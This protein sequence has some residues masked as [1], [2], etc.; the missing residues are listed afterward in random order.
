MAEK[1]LSKNQVIA[2][3]AR[4]SHGDLKQYLPI[5][6]SSAKEDPEF[7]AHL[8]AW[9][10]KNGQIRDSKIAL[11]VTSLTMWHDDELAENSLAHMALLDPRS[12]VKAVEFS[13]KIKTLLNGK[14]IERLVEAYLR[15]REKKRGW[16]DATALQHRASMKTLYAMNHIKPS[17]RADKIL[18]KRSY[19]KNSAF[20]ALRELKNMTPKD[21]AAAIINKELP[22]QIAIGALGAKAKDPDVVLALIEAMSPTQLT[23]S[24]KMLERLGLNTNPALKAAFEI[25]LHKVAASPKN[26]LKAT[27]AIEAL[28][29]EDSPIKEK[30]KKTQEKQIDAMG[31]VKG[32]WLVLGDKSGSMHEA[33]DTARHIAATLARM[34]EDDVWL[35]FFDTTPYKVIQA[36]GKTYDELLAESKRVTAGGG[37]SIG[38]GLQHIL[39]K[40]IEVDGIAVVSDGGENTH[41]V[42]PAVYKRYT[43]KFAKDVPVYYYDLNGEPNV[44]FVQ[45]MQKAGHDM[46]TF[47][48]R[49]SK[50]DYYSLPNLV[51][52]MSVSRYG[53]IDQIMET[54]LL[55]VKDVLPSSQWE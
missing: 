9:N 40:D 43:E 53:L 13:K 17:D 18:F 2:E 45:A 46:Q 6:K 24:V 42:F 23:N 14:A 50:V 12:L 30:L 25:G 37:T 10:E 29:E 16:W 33:I 20:Y 31:K 5:V 41:P 26:T 34:A 51:K 4:S 36:K 15:E 19:A 35:V 1:S 48:L 52:T 38:C 22:F 11:P 8:I 21:A 28:G 49:G 3:L 7:L 27:K 47:S 44:Y 32:R 55:R 39:D 54:K